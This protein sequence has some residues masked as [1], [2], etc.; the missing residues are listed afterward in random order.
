MK[1]KNIKILFLFVAALSMASCSDFL[2]KA[3]KTSQSTEVTLSNFDGLNKAA[4][5]ALMPMYDWYGT[6]YV[7]ANEMRSGN[8]RRE[9]SGTFQSG[10][11]YSEY[12]WNY[13]A[14]ATSGMW[15]SCYYV[16][17]AANSV[18]ANLEG[19]DS[20]EGVTAQDLDN[21]KAECLFIRALC[22]HTLVLYYAQPFTYQ[23]DGLGVP[24]IIEPGDA[25]YFPARNTTREVYTQIVEDLLEAEKIMA[26]DYQRSGVTD[27]KATI[28][29]PAIQALLSRVY[30]YMGEWQKAADYA[31]KVIN[32]EAYELWT[33]EE[34]PTV[35]TKDVAGDGGE[36]IFEIYGKKTADYYNSWSDIS[37]VTN[38]NGYADGGVSNDLYKLYADNDV[39][40]TLHR[41]DKENV[42]GGLMWTTK[43]AGKGDGT[44]DCNNIIVL[45]LSEMYLNRAEAIL[46]G[47]SISGTT[48]IADVNAIRAN[49][50][51][52]ALTS[53]GF[54]DMKLERRLEL[55]YEGHYLWDLGRWGDGVVR[56]D[57]TAGD[58]FKD[59]PFPSYKWALPISQSELDINPN[60]VQNPEY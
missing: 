47:A 11:F 15:E 51:V 2:E 34:L 21:L 20:E 35:W 49:R 8:G 33:A 30:L 46:N 39:R 9:A 6:S 52:D 23:P 28:T 18:I 55:A 54:A 32:N 7:L 58:N 13:S 38:P 26:D 12:V 27:A 4:Y 56:E 10:R 48:A 3:P 1:M 24:N 37:Y 31:T 53:L 5:G 14:D 44:P 41:T 29:K 45:R 50:G 40:K 42:S 57:F 43:Y 19:K 36:V 59:I 17:H 25:N 60:L 16:I 22:H